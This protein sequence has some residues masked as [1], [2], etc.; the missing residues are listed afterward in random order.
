MGYGDQLLATGM[1]RGAYERG[2]LIAF[3]NPTVGRIEWD[4]HSEEV[5]RGNPNIA[6]P[7]AEMRSTTLTWVHFYRGNRIYNRD[8]HNNSRWIWN[9]KFRPTPGELFFSPEE[10]LDAIQTIG[11]NF[12]VV[13]PNVPM[14]RVG[15]NKEWPVERYQAVADALRKDGHD[16][17]QLEY[18][19]MQ[20]TLQRVRLVPSKSFR[21]ALALLERA[22][23][24]V[25]CEGGLHHGAAAVNVP[26]VV[27][28]GGFVPPEVTGYDTH[29]NLAAEGQGPPCGKYVPCAHC[30][31][32]MRSITIERVLDAARGLL[33][34][35][36][37]A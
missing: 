18:H 32:A 37:A 12:V 17:V 28:F 13:E 5:F 8:D 27:L 16:V 10:R 24:I 9:Y 33:A 26:A 2:E 35:K 23:L 22:S 7:G 19:G 6:P 15:I 31:A 36:A 4:H 20:R 3:G 25:T 30:M 29:A 34:R 11:K 1:A 21:R 14:K